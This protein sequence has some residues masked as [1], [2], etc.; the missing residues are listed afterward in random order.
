MESYN[1]SFALLIIVNRVIV[2]AYE[3]IC[4]S[5]ETSGVQYFQHISR[6][7]YSDNSSATDSN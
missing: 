3:M 7:V 2:I 4:N 1:L 5:G 6:A